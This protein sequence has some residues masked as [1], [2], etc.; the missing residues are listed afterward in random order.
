MSE[1]ALPRIPISAMLGS[2]KSARAPY[3]LHEEVVPR[4][5]V[6]VMMLIEN[7]R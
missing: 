7:F 2:A 5:G 4:A 3:F 1:L 6:R